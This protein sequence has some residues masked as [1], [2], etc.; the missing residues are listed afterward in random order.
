MGQ[1]AV[2]LDFALKEFTMTILAP[3]VMFV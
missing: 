1:V 3:L 2:V